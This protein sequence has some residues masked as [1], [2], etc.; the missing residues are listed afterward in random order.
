MNGGRRTTDDDDDETSHAGQAARNRPTDD[1]LAA[2]GRKN[3]TVNNTVGTWKVRKGEPRAGQSP[4]EWDGQPQRK[5][6]NMG[7]RAGTLQGQCT[8]S[9]PDKMDIQSKKASPPGATLRAQQWVGPA[10]LTLNH[11]RLPFLA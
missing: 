3:P 10:R 4:V 8:F 2:A 7:P 11:V 6:R 1:E 5:K 9:L